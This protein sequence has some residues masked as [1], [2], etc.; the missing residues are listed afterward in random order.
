MHHKYVRYLRKS[1]TIVLIILSAVRQVK[2]H[3]SSTILLLAEVAYLDML[4]IHQQMHAA[5]SV[6]QMKNK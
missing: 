5:G 4:F 2:V 1:D 3:L 6:C